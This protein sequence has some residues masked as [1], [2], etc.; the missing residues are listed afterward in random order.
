MSHYYRWNR[1]Q[2]LAK[3]VYRDYYVDAVR[4]SFKANLHQNGS[5]HNF[6]GKI[7]DYRQLLCI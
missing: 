6:S 2:I 5:R 4:K 1:R 3:T 7:V